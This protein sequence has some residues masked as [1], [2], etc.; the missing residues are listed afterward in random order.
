MLPAERLGRI[1]GAL[2]VEGRPRTIRGAAC[3]KTVGRRPVL[4]GPVRG[5]PPLWGRWTAGAVSA[6]SGIGARRALP[7]QDPFRHVPRLRVPGWVDWRP[8]RQ[9]DV[10]LDRLPDVVLDNNEPVVGAAFAD[11]LQV[12]VPINV[13]HVEREG[14]AGTAAC[15][16]CR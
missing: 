6:G 14:R 9:L 4:D 10:E 15:G 8:R 5:R 3:K 11:P 2:L 1:L 7:C 12:A 13:L 16:G